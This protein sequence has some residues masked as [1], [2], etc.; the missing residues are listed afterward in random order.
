MAAGNRSSGDRQVQGARRAYASI[1]DADAAPAAGAIA[2]SAPK[3]NPYRTATTLF[4]FPGGLSG[5][6]EDS[7]ADARRAPHGRPNAA[8]CRSARYRTVGLL[9]H[10]SGENRIRGG[11]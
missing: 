10:G 4:Q 9:R 2:G 5:P 11:A 1:A 7:R 6:Q 3:G 8:I